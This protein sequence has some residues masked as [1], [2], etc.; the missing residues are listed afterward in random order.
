M[1]QLK[2]IQVTK[3]R[4]SKFVKHTPLYYSVY[5]SKISNH[6]VYLKL[7][8]LLYKKPGYNPFSK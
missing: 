1:I 6:H 7:E 2:D 8:N 4:I 3:D 5:F